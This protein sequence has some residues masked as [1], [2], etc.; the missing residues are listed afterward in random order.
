MADAI[1]KVPNN[2]TVQLQDSTKLPLTGGTLT[3]N[4]TL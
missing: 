3:G 4:L 1:F 2:S